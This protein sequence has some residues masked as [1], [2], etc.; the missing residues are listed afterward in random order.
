MSSGGAPSD[1]PVRLVAG[2]VGRPHGLDGSF[3]VEQAR[4]E[5]LTIGAE[6]EVGEARVQVNRRA[7]TDHR[8]IIRLEGV[9]GRSAAESMRGSRLLIEREDAPALGPDEWWA[10]D[11]EACTVTD[12]ERVLGTVR[13]L[14]ALPSCEVLE[15][16]VSAAGADDGDEQAP[17]L[18]IP[19]VRDAVR[20]V[21]VG[22][23]R[24]DVDT[25]FLG[26]A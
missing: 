24:I 18:L 19:L 23:R 6:L 1:P 22:A 26:D 16:A 7:G 3:Y 12:G 4:A 9:E 2:V 20:S 13:R 21:D 5:L 14:L 15:V 17:T 10:E 25:R 8:P 11:L